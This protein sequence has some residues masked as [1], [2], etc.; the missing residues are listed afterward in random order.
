MLDEGLR[1]VEALSHPVQKVGR[2]REGGDLAGWVAT[3]VSKIHISTGHSGQ[4][5][6]L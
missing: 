5:L 6:H 3:T 2:V 1:V 4:R